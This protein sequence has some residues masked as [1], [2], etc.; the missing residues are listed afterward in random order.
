LKKK[1]DWYG[2]VGPDFS[3]PVAAQES[4]FAP[5][6]QVR[7]ALEERAS[8]DNSLGYTYVMTGI[9]SDF[10]VEN[11]ILGLSEDKRTATFLGDPDSLLT[12]THTDECVL[13]FW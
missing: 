10:M 6:L 1:A 11:N 8:K 4:F 9:F 2:I 7:K 5:K 3:N 13:I 12:S